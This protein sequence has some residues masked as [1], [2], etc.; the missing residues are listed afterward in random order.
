MKRHGHT[1]LLFRLLLTFAVILAFAT[2]AAVL[3]DASDSDQGPV[4]TET[5][6]ESTATEA[7]ATV[8]E[9]ETTT[10]TDV[11]TEVP[12]DVPTVV[13]TEEVPETAIATEAPATATEVPTDIPT[14]VPTETPEATATETATETAT[15]TQTATATATATA[16]ATSTPKTVKTMSLQGVNPAAAISCTIPSG[17]PTVAIGSYITF[18]CTGDAPLKVRGDSLTSGWQWAY[19]YGSVITPTTWYTG[20]F[21]DPGSASGNISTVYIYLGPT[22]SVL[23]GA[24]GSLTVSVVKPNGDLQSSTTVTAYAGVGPANFSLTCTPSTITVPTSTNGTVNCSLSG[25]NLAPEAVVSVT[26]VN[27]SSLPSWTITRS[28]SSGTLTGTTPFTFSLS[29]TPVCGAAVNPPAPNI[30]IT[31]SLSFHGTVVT[32][33]STSITAK[34]GATSNVSASISGSAL[35][36]SQTYSFSQQSVIGS[37]TYRVTASGCAGWNIQ[38]SATNFAYTG[39]N[40]GAPIANG[41]IAVTPGSVSG[42]SGSSTT[43]V[44]PGASGSLAAALKVLA[45]TENSGIGTYDQSLGVN[46][47]IPGGARVGTYTSTVTITASSGP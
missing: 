26:S 7:I 17:I 12:T 34:H 44:T 30:S 46:V 20:S 42:V 1:F 28:P 8:E 23:A 19:S 39:S 14:S 41:N 27:V 9:T 3:A 22:S 15:A 18:Q 6:A 5:S 25:V 2:P 40:S 10:A 37:L 43:N 16:S 35:T 36:W 4:Q 29:L 45:A 31:T 47:L 33:P 13:P 24:T 32:G 11:P 38:F 21:T